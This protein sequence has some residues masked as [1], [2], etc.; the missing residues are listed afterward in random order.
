MSKRIGYSDWYLPSKDELNKLYINKE[1]IGGFVINWYLSSTEGNSNNVWAQ[2]L[3]NG[4]Q[5]LLDLGSLYSVRAV[6]AF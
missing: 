2:S 1:A 6:R 5:F 4:L 3:Y